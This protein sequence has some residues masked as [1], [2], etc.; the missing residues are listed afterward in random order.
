MALGGCAGG[1]DY[2]QA[3]RL[4]VC[5]AKETTPD[6]RETGVAS[7]M[8][9]RAARTANALRDAFAEAVLPSTLDD[10]SATA[11]GATRPQEEQASPATAPAE[12][13]ETSP[14][15]I[16]FNL[17]GQDN[18]QQSRQHGVGVEISPRKGKLPYERGGRAELLA[19][20]VANERTE[21]ALWQHA[22]IRQRIHERPMPDMEANVVEVLQSR[23]GLSL[24]RCVAASTAIQRAITATT[25]GMRGDHAS[26]SVSSPSETSFYVLLSDPMASRAGPMRSQ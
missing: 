8:G 12:H 11:N 23:P 15:S 17:F 21:Y 26:Q 3:C 24:C 9:A 4:T 10:P 18:Q 20:L 6:K 14:S 25:M 16:R 19:R 13:Q 1:C 22:L 5:H 2:G 7:D